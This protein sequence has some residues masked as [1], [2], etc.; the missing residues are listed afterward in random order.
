MDP[1]VFQAMHWFMQYSIAIMNYCGDYQQHVEN[2]DRK[3]EVARIRIMVALEYYLK[4]DE[5]AD[6]IY[7]EGHKEIP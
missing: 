6:R 3:I 2:K 1:V 7:R 4:E 5:V